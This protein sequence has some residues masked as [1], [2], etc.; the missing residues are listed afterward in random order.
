MQPAVQEARPPYVSFE[1]RAVEDRAASEANGHYT[2][3][4][5][6]FA[7]ITPSGSKDRI[8]RIATEWLIYLDDQ[9]KQQR[10]PEEWARAYRDG[11]KRWAADQLPDVT[12]TS[13][14]NWP[15]A[16]PAMAK[17]MLQWNVRT[18][19][20]LAAANEET[21]SRLGMG[22]RDLKRRAIEWLASADSIGKTSERMAGLESRAEAQ[23]KQIAA[24]ME[25]NALLQRQLSSAL[26]GQLIGQVPQAG[27]QH[28]NGVELHDLVDTSETPTMKR[29]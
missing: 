28:G 4:D 19:E 22:A 20:D 1:K 6:D 29:L 8:E 26:Q 14:Q 16:S 2:S 3:K 5:V 10:F 11:Y 12:G 23:D 17:N 7:I 25:T 21:L 15:P 24:L 9:V 13:I 18:V 27:D